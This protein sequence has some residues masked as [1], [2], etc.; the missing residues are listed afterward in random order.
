MALA[1]KMTKNTKFYLRSPLV[2]PVYLI[3]IINLIE[4]NEKD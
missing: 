2:I 3:F 1:R 4:Q